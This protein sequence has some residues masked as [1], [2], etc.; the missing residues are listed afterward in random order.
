MRVRADE[1][2]GKKKTIQQQRTREEK[3]IMEN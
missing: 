3:R 2:R 1:K